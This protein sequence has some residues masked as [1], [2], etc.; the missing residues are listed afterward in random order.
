MNAAKRRTALLGVLLLAGALAGVLAYGRME[1]MKEDA[2][3]AERDLV[4]ATSSMREIA[5]WRSSPSRAAAPGAMEIPQLNARLRQAATAAGLPDAP[6]SE[7]GSPTRLEGGD[8]SELPVFLRF[9]PL[10]LK[11]LTSF[12]VALSRIDPSA[13]ARAIELSP[14]EQAGTTADARDGEELW[15]AGVEVDYLS[16]TP[17]RAQK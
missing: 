6:G 5:R 1:R 2:T 16:Y 7:P 15:S 9:E 14:P 11:Q 17:A 8:Y 13:R 3:A 4:A 12:L 10:T